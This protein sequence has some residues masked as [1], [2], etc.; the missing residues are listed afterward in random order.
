M[1]KFVVSAFAMLL[2]TFMTDFA[3]IALATDHVR[4][5]RNPETWNIGGFV[6]VSVALGLCML[7]EALALLWFA[8]LPFGLAGHDEALHT[9]SFLLL[10]YLAVFSIISAR[11][12]RWFWTTMPSATLI[13][14]LSADVLVGT[15]LT[16][17]GLPS[18]APLPWWQ[19]LVLLAYAMVSCL[20]V[21]DAVKVTLTRWLIPGAAA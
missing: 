16:Y 2:L 5:S 4:S 9:F 7:A 21:N 1:G 15:A 10:L 20:V 8:W 3:K 6:A 17:V 13:A 14:A 12:R 11:E 18:L 19:T